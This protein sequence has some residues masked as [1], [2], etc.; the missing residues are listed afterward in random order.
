M[1]KERAQKITNNM[2]EKKVFQ[3]L[4]TTFKSW[5][6]P[7]SWSVNFWGKW[8][9]QKNDFNQQTACEAPVCWSKYITTKVKFTCPFK[10]CKL[11]DLNLLIL[12][13]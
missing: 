4:G 9:A 5:L 11:N 8:G 12:Q 1:E 13:M 7:K 10:Q 6:T 3:C 2:H